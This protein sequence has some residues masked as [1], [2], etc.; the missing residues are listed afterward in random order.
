[1]QRQ[2]SNE[3]GEV[4]ILEEILNLEMK[5][6]VESCKEGSTDV[7]NRRICTKDFLEKSFLERRIF[8][9]NQTERSKK[10][11]RSN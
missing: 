9:F 8:G 6:R 7:E 5:I 1:L 10:L 3:A 2:E 4:T 11:E